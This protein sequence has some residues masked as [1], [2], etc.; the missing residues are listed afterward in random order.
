MML[1]SPRSELLHA[2]EL[3]L[4]IFLIIVVPSSLWKTVDLLEFQVVEKLEVAFG[5]KLPNPT[6]SKVTLTL[7]SVLVE[8]SVLE[9]CVYPS[10]MNTLYTPIKNYW[11]FW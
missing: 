8:D 1:R 2:T 9:E 11:Q 10:G 3:L 5:S 6:V 7:D 4:E